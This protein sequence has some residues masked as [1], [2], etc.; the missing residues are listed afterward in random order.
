M[1]LYWLSSNLFQ[2]AQQFYLLRKYHEPISF[3]D[4]EHLITDV[5]APEN[6]D[7]T[8]DGGKKKLPKQSSAAKTY[9]VKK[10]TKGA[11]S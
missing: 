2:M 7:A 5:P 4:S 8:K 1:V 11:N 9:K 6:D 3:L 10:K